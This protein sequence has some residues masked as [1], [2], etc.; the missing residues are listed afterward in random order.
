MSIVNS[1]VFFF[2]YLL[3]KKIYG[4]F[5]CFTRQ[6]ATPALNDSKFVMELMYDIIHMSSED[7][8]SL[9]IY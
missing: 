5:L 7:S 2:R 6:T 4:R 1:V 9:E 8:L 3:S